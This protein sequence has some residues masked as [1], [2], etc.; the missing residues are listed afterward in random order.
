MCGVRERTESD[1]HGPGGGVNDGGA[2]FDTRFYLARG[3]GEGRPS[4]RPGEK[5]LYLPDAPLRS[6]LSLP[7][8]L[9]IIIRG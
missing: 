8:S 7:L 6:T 5:E 3:T 4:S 2:A 9:S 1:N